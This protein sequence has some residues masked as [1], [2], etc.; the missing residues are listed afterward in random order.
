MLN[1]FT[2]NIRT[3]SE[4]QRLV[5]A[6]I[7]ALRSGKYEQ[8]RGSLRTNDDTYCCLGVA[9]DVY[10]PSRWDRNTYP[11]NEWSYINF[12]G[13]LP[14][15]VQ[16]AFCL[17][18]AGGEFRDENGDIDDNV[19]CLAARNDAPSGSSFHRNFSEIADMIE[20][21]LNVRLAETDE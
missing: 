7:D 15:E 3:N 4:A 8:G 5:R 19:Y 21:D 20:H 12:V 11:Y 13:D 9:C 6:W 18:G 10:D 2:P 17:V 1:L 14:A 16:E